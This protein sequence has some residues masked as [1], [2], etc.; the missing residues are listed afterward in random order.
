MIIPKEI[1][2]QLRVPEKVELNKG[3]V[4]EVRGPDGLML[5][6]GKREYPLNPR[7]S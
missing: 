4:R 3:R 7:Q 1:A 5:K 2:S 6:V